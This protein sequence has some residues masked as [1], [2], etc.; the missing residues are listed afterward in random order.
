MAY[1]PDSRMV[2]IPVVD[3]GDSFHAGQLF[4]RRGMPFWRSMSAPDAMGPQEF[5]G[6]LLALDAATGDTA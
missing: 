6:S 5:A 2:Y 3:N 4:Y 1:S